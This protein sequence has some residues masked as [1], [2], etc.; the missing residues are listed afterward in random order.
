[1]LKKEIQQ[2]LE[3]IEET[4]S[5]YFD[6]VE[7]Y[8]HFD[9]FSSLDPDDRAGSSELYKQ[10][11]GVVGQLSDV[12]EHSLLFDELDQQTL[13]DAL[14]RTQAA[15]RL[16]KYQSWDTHVLHDEDIIL[17]VTKAGHGEYPTRGGH[18]GETTPQ[19][20]R[21]GQ[22]SRPTSQQVDQEQQHRQQQEPEP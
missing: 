18:S 9:D 4:A 20:H 11:A 13:R 14:R 2:Q 15:L 16:R 5:N 22:S 7:T 19:L 10:I 12:A 21:D 8:E 17:G 3:S 1:M 6:K